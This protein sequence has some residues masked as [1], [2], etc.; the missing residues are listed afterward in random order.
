MWGQNPNFLGILEGEKPLIVNFFE[1]IKTV[2]NN[3]KLEKTN[4]YNVLLIKR[5][6]SDVILIFNRHSVLCKLTNE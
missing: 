5:Q 1:E 4:F 2:E 3:Q 6:F